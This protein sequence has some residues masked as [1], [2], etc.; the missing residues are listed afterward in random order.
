MKFT[1]SPHQAAGH[2]GILEAGPVFAKLTTDQEIDFYAESRRR[3]TPDKPLGDDL[4]DWMPTYMGVLTQGAIA[5]NADSTDAIVLKDGDDKLNETESFADLAKNTQKSDQ[6]PSLQVS[7]SSS[8]INGAIE[9]SKTA[10]SKPDHK[11][12]VLQNLLWGY[13]YPCILDIK[14]G[15]VLVDDSV[16]EEKR[17]RL[18]K[19]SAETTSGSLHFRICGMKTYNGHSD[20]KPPEVFEGQSETVVVEQSDSGNYLKYNKFFGRQLNMTNVKDAIDLFFVHNG[21]ASLRKQLISKFHQRLQLIYNSVLDA[22]VRIKSGS[23]LFCYDADPAKWTEQVFDQDALVD[24]GEIEDDSGDEEEPAQMS[25]LKLIDFAHSKYVEGEGS[26][27]N[28]LVGIENLV[29]LFSE[30]VQDN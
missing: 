27:E 1:P 21:H 14:L 17:Q 23:L 8:T 9:S 12:I 26:D 6:S 2:A 29:N 5:N 3:H 16:T 4:Y 30:L 10:A 19:V 25:N 28:V 18:A 15:S 20:V 22:E 7:D 11:Y 13:K 24:E